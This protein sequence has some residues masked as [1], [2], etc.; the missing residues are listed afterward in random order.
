M[1]NDIINGI[2]IKLNQAFETGYTILSEESA[3]APEK[4]YFLIQ[5]VEDSVEQLVDNRYKLSALIEITYFT[6]QPNKNQD[7][8]D[9][10]M[11]LY[12][13]L[14]HITV[15]DSLVRGIGLKR[16]VEKERLHMFVTYRMTLTKPSSI[17]DTMA[18]V[19][20]TTS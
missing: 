15:A 13:V 9:V 19:E 14:E 1:I 8:N 2:S 11:T 17:G 6:D 5:A 3:Q 12:D 7:L 20:M 10:A 16:T 18:T 4:P